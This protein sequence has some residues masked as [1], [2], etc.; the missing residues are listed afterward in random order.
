MGESTSVI[1]NI[2]E[3]GMLDDE[4][5]V[6]YGDSQ[7]GL[8]ILQAPDGAWRT[9]HLRLRC[10][11]IRERVNMGLWKVRHLAGA[12]LAADLLTKPV[13]QLG[14]WQAFMLFMNLRAAA[15]KT[16]SEGPETPGSS[17]PK[18]LCLRGW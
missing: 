13:T 15:S 9:R 5:G 16:A 7:T 11:A 10:F 17:G 4:L 2:L 6:L 14:A 12:K 1:V 3:Q 18:W 8:K